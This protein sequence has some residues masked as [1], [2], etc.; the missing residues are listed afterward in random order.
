MEWADDFSTLFELL[1][2]GVYRTEASSKQVRANRAMVRIFGFG[3]EAEM[4]AHPRSS[5]AGWYADPARRAQ[6]RTELETQGEVRNFVSE[7]C[8]H[9]TGEAFW[10]AENAHA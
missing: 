8:R 6:F 5:G 2:I 10:I 9:G 1:P 3:S 4:L 7:M